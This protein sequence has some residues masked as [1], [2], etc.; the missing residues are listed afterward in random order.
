MKEEIPSFVMKYKYLWRWRRFLVILGMT[1]FIG[2]FRGEM[3]RNACGI[4]PHLPPLNKYYLSFRM[5]RSEMRNL[6][7]FFA[8]AERAF[9]AEAENCRK[10]STANPFDIKT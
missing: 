2:D 1:L 4:P 8:S 3:R 10:V 5:E 9:P 6:H 7:P